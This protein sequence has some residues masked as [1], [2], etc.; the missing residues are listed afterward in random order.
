[1]FDWLTT[2]L[3]TVKVVKWMFWCLRSGNVFWFKWNFIDRPENRNKDFDWLI[4]KKRFWLE[5]LTQTKFIKSNYSWLPSFEAYFR[6]VLLVRIQILEYRSRF[7]HQ[8]KPRKPQEGKIHLV[9]SDAR[10]F[11]YRL[12]VS[13][14]Q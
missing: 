11:M 1:M 8:G 6:R 5:A 9:T 4:K 14:S 7:R 2:S 12:I 10:I 3:T 13:G